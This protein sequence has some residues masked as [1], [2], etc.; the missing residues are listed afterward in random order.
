[1]NTSEIEKMLAKKHQ[2]ENLMPY[3]REHAKYLCRV[4]RTCIVNESV[5]ITDFISRIDTFI[6]V[7]TCHEIAINKYCNL[8]LATHENPLGLEYDYTHHPSAK[9]VAR[10][11]RV[12][13]I[14]RLVQAELERDPELSEFEVY[15]NLERMQAEADTIFRCPFCNRVLARESHERIVD[16]VH[17]D[18]TED[19]HLSSEWSW[20]EDACCHLIYDSTDGS[21]GWI[22]DA[23][24]AFYD[25]CTANDI[26]HQFIDDLAV[27]DDYERDGHAVETINF[28]G[29][30]YYGGK[31]YFVEDVDAF[32]EH[33]KKSVLKYTD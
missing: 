27:I 15:K 21:E 23:N 13:L 4:L 24:D 14:W 28:Y 18:G 26:K 31:W 12:R 10:D 33:V 1:M 3:Y 2:R 22:G 5:D 19:W 29:I 8:A 20:E 9:N 17:A 6:A 32:V 7:A 30:H 25:T 11:L 16:G